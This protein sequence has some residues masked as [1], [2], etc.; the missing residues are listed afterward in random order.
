MGWLRNNWSELLLTFFYGVLAIFLASFLC[1][2]PGCT[3]GAI[4]VAISPDPPV[5]PEGMVKLALAVESG[6]FQVLDGAVRVE[7]GAASITSP[8]IPTEPLNR[9]ADGFVL[10]AVALAMWIAPNPKAVWQWAVK[11]ANGA[12]K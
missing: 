6:A 12:L 11:K 9:M 4:Q 3:E 2:G 8:E 5:I 10:V 1:S 7:A